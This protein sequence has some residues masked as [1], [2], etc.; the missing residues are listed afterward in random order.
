[1]SLQGY[2]LMPHPPI[3]LPEVGKGEEKKIGKTAE[4]M[5]SVG[6]EIAKAAPDT[7]VLVTPHGTMFQ[8]AIVL[9]YENEIS[10][11]M[12]NFGAP[13]VDIRQPVQMALTRRIYDMAQEEGIPAILATGALMKKYGAKVFADHGALVPLYFINRYY[14]DYSVI[15]ITY[16][17]LS[18]VELYRFGI[19]INK[20][21][22]EAGSNA[23]F[24]ASGDLSH[25]LKEDGP[26]GLDPAGNIFDK[27]FLKSLQE[28]DIKRVFSIDKNIISD[29]GEC[30]RR[31]VAVML[32]A[33]E[34][35]KFKG[36]LLS[37]ED[38]FGVGYGVVKINV[39]SEDTPRLEQL[40][41]LRTAAYEKKTRHTDPYVRLA[42][43]SLT[44]YLETGEEYSGIP[45][46]ITDEMKHTRRGVFVSLKKNGELRGCI[47]TI[48]P[49][50]DSIAEEI[51]R[52]A[53][54]AG[55]NDPR[56]Y[57]VE[58]DELM[59]I[60]FSVDVLTEPQTACK[61]ELNPEE[62]G[63]IVRCKGKTGLLLPA[64]EGVD[65]VDEQL[66]IA[67]KKAGIN[68]REEYSIEKFKVIRHKEE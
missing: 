7:I 54:E 39:L 44:T 22:K 26:Y 57:Q 36:D 29:A 20:A 31:S 59:D 15:H 61:D 66:S 43:E 17:P 18:D 4:S 32:G 63:V 14:R 6:R 25:R 3:V 30:G 53:V 58:K 16:A 68:P 13:G 35:M 11:S 67:L 55:L 64:L 65:T 2:Y 52:N 45:D 19:V 46:Y 42:R 62:Y 10:G 27:E 34:G 5:D 37:Y 24:V 9:S 12:K 8:D 51:I 48:F 50:T 23:V 28:G 60:D 38:T 41:A 40:Q 47:G 21:I 33:L 49:T 56:F 1:M